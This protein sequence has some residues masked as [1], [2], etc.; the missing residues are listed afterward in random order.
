MEQQ[1]Q[2]MGASAP[3]PTH[4]TSQHQGTLQVL[5]PRVPSVYPTQ[6][7]E[8]SEPN[9]PATYPALIEFS[10]HKESSSSTGVH[11]DMSSSCNASARSEAILSHPP[12]SNPPDTTPAHVSSPECLGALEPMQP[13]VSS[14]SPHSSQSTHPMYVHQ[15]GKEGS[16]AATAA[17]LRDRSSSDSTIQ[18][19]QKGIYKHFTL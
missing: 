8:T 4:I 10:S 17:T 7:R 9:S 18:R 3:E 11:E 12:G 13:R 15:Q 16:L 14:Q 5:T 19:K 1:P 6:H 2:H